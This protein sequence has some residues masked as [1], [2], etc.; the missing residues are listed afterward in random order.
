MHK[1]HDLRPQNISWETVHPV[2]NGESEN[3]KIHNIYTTKGARLSRTVGKGK[4]AQ[5]EINKILADLSEQGQDIKASC[6]I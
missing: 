6:R 5:D 1:P 4:Y 3:R 2:E